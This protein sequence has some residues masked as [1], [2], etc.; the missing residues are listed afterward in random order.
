M[1][2]PSTGL[3]CLPVRAWED[4]KGVDAMK[5]LLRTNDP[6]RLSYISALLAEGRI[7]TL[8]LDNHM[9]VLEGSIGAIARRLMVPNEDHARAVRILE[10]AGVLSED[11]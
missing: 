9:S 3:E 5:E 2:R 11:G 8:V 6:V 10:E 7:E 1:K 4:N